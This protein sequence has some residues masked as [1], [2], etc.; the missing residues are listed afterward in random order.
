[1]GSIETWAVTLLLILGAFLIV[2]HLGVD[3]GSAVTQ[4]VHGVERFLA[5]PI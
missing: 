4:M 5:R 3:A 1:M 2:G